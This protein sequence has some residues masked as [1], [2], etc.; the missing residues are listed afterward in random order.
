MVRL[1][2]IH[3]VA[4]HAESVG[5]TFSN[6]LQGSRMDRFVNCLAFFGFLLGIGC[7]PAPQV[8]EKPP[9]APQPAAKL[10]EKGSPS[11]T[12]VVS[13]FLDEVR[14]GGE[15]SCANDLL[16][17]RA[18]AELQRIGR[19]VQPIGSPDAGFLVTRA[20]S[21]PGEDDSAL[22]HSVWSEPNADGSKSE[23]Q[24]VWAVQQEPAG[25]RISGLAMEL[26]S[27][28]AP[29]IIDFENGE[30]MAKLLASPDFER[31]NASAAASQAAVTDDEVSR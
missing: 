3:P 14:R 31:K 2:A 17:K 12:D 23:F 27:D 18:Q 9:T 28:Q 22:V 21:V 5:I 29:V 15:D 11:P 1:D 19:S 7:G 8:A 16:T 30:L 26:A 20:E 25:W 4:I 24:V 13:Q 10:S 6:A